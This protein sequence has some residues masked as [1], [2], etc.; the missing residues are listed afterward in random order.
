MDGQ[1]GWVTNAW[2]ISYVLSNEYNCICQVK[3][4]CDLIDLLKIYLFHDFDMTNE[5]AWQLYD[6]I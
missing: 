4:F 1:D 3:D 5:T 2:W 6:R